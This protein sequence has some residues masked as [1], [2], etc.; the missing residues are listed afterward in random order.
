MRIFGGGG[1]GWGGWPHLLGSPLPLIL[2][3]YRRCVATARRNLQA[4]ALCENATH[5]GANATR[6]THPVQARPPS[7]RKQS[8]TCLLTLDYAAPSVKATPSLSE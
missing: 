1:G 6:M 2:P 8:E 3:C 5:G 4:I 7:L